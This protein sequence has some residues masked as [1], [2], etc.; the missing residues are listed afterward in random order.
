MLC[1][2]LGNEWLLKVWK[3]ILLWEKSH[4][5]NTPTLCWNEK[6]PVFSCIGEPANLKTKTSH[7]RIK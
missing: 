5:L 4:A 7:V 1:W 6:A 2:G 3:V